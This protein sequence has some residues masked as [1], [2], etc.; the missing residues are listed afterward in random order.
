MSLAPRFRS[1]P[2]PGY[3]L[4]GG[5]A[6]ELVQVPN[7]S[8]SFLSTSTPKSIRSQRCYLDFN[9]ISCCLL[10]RSTRCL[11]VSPIQ[12]TVLSKCNWW[13][14]IAKAQWT[15]FYENPANVERKERIRK[16]RKVLPKIG[17]RAQKVGKVLPK[18]NRRSGP[19]PTSFSKFIQLCATCNKAAEC[20]FMRH[21][22]SR[23]ALA[24]RLAWRMCHNSG[25]TSADG[26]RKSRDK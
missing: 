26:L 15:S 1:R 12:R 16:C 20:L 14:I 6:K 19:K 7:P 22:W 24:V 11:I 25:G 2:E 9:R 18:I 5:Y 3:A 4:E 21:D 10:R 13:G 17:R 23:R 8:K